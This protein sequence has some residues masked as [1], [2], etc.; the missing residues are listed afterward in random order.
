MTDCLN[1]FCAELIG[2][3]GTAKWYRELRTWEL[4]GVRAEVEHPM[5]QS[6][7]LLHLDWDVSSLPNSFCW[8]RNLNSNMSSIHWELTLRDQF[9]KTMQSLLCM[10]QTDSNKSKNTV[11]LT[12]F[13]IFKFLVRLRIVDIFSFHLQNLSLQDNTSLILLHVSPHA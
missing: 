11:L 3:G 13:S 9:Y 6:D 1:H 10:N 5:S 4:A 12:L 8:K 2:L 7:D